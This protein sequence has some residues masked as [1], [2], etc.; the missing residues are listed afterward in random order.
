MSFLQVL[1][2]P[3]AV[4]TLGGCSNPAPDFE[5]VAP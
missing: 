2:L 1:L 4:M 5:M 3:G